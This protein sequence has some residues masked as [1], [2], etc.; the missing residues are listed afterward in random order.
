MELKKVIKNG[1]INM[2]FQ[3]FPIIFALTMVPY[4][5][6]VY[7]DRGFGVFSMSITMVVLFNYLNFGIAQAATKELAKYD[8]ESDNG[9]ISEIFWSGSFAIVGV[10]LILSVL[11]IG[12]YENLATL[13]LKNEPIQV[14]LKACRMFFLV[15]LASP[16]FLYVIY[17]RGCLESQQLFT[18]TAANRAFLNSFIFLSPI[19]ANYLGKDISYCANLIIYVHLFSV[20]L[21]SIPVFYKLKPSLKIIINGRSIV[22]LLSCGGWMTITSLSSVALY[23]S[24]RFF[25]S[26]LIG[27]SAVAYYVS[28]FDL[29]SRTSIIYGSLTAALFPAFSYW[30]SKGQRETIINSINFTNVTI[31]FLMLVVSGVFI[32]FG[33]DILFFWIISE[34][35]NKSAHLLQVLS[36]GVFFNAMSVVSL[37]G[38]LAMGAEKIVGIYYLIQS[39]IYILVSLFLIKLYGTIGA[40]IAF[41]IRA[42]LEYLSL[43]SILFIGELGLDKNSLL[44]TFFKYAIYGLTFISLTILLSLITSME[45]KLLIS[46]VFLVFIIGGGL[47]FFQ[48]DFLLKVLCR[49]GCF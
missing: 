18:Y 48:R 2:G 7:G 25:I 19:L 44:S 4:T 15:G 34:Y 10:G 40:C 23:Y 9:K 47:L 26:N 32:I 29:I 36:V 43:S 11:S 3:I 49:F 13:V 33:K 8:P 30:K 31:F 14:V 17:L 1:I 16:L 21:L 45:L 6:K 20:I 35:S 28:A 42:L 37:R 12:G 38:L 39:F 41:S 46:A 27:L 22:Y 24:D 5:I